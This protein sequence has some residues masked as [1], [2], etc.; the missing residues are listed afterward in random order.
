MSKKHF[1]RFLFVTLLLILSAA[2]LTACASPATAD[3]TE[4]PQDMG[5]MTED[6]HTMQ[7]EMEDGMVPN[8]GAVIRIVS[9][10]DG[11]TFAVG[12]DIKVEIEVENFK[13]NDDGSHWHIYVNGSSYSMVTGETYSWVVRGLEPGEHEI[14]AHL[15]LGTHQDLEEGA[16]IHVTI[17]E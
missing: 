14:M 1:S 13:L 11:A 9:P 3:P 16:M 2:F 17:T 12:D 7:H 5:D 4:V 15:A 6:E 8:D 10:A